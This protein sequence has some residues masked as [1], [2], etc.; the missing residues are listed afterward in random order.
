MSPSAHFIKAQ[1]FDWNVSLS[2]LDGAVGERR[3]WGGQACALTSIKIVISNQSAHWPTIQNITHGRT[4]GPRWVT[5]LKSFFTEPRDAD[6][7][8]WDGAPLQVV[9]P[10]CVLT[11]VAVTRIAV[12]CLVS[13][14]VA[15]LLI[16]S[17]VPV[18]GKEKRGGG[19]IFL[20]RRM[21]KTSSSRYGFCWRLNARRGASVAKNIF[22]QPAFS[23]SSSSSLPSMCPF[24]ERVFSQSMPR[25]FLFF[26]HRWGAQYTIPVGGVGFSCILPTITTSPWLQKPKPLHPS[27]RNWIKETR[28]RAAVRPPN[29]S[30]AENPQPTVLRA[31]F[32]LL[33][34]FFYPFFKNYLLIVVGGRFS[35]GSVKT[36]SLCVFVCVCVCVCMGGS[37]WRIISITTLLYAFSLFTVLPCLIMFK[38]HCTGLWQRREPSRA[39]LTRLDGS[40]THD[41]IPSKGKISQPLWG[42]LQTRL[43]FISTAMWNQ[44]VFGTMKSKLFC[45]RCKKKKSWNHRLWDAKIPLQPADCLIDPNPRIVVLLQVRIEAGREDGGGAV[46]RSATSILFIYCYFQNLKSK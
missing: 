41:I 23:S 18:S 44:C 33:L 26:P 39:S 10:F 1:M 11:F 13:C 24:C 16:L 43:I 34:F 30:R 6:K 32:F 15:P 38:Q 19:S 8:D 17:Y 25:F 28:F 36:C 5:R 21:K 4:A 42:C 27:L 20:C 29:P 14:A 9:F 37:L 22:V 31:S 46:V 35:C 45:T 3:R 7:A 12:S 40:Q 2:P